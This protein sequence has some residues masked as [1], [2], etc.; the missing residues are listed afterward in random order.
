M[1]L[2]AVL[3]GILFLSSCSYYRFRSVNLVKVNS[4]KAYIHSE[5]LHDHDVFIRVNKGAASH[6]SVITVS[7]VT[8]SDDSIHFSLD[9]VP[10]F[11]A[12]ENYY[13]KG[14]DKLNNSRKKM[15][16]NE[17]KYSDELDFVNQ[18][19]FL[20]NDSLASELENTV[21]IQRNQITKM[22]VIEDN[23]LYGFL[24]LLGI[25]TGLIVILLPIF[26]LIA[27]SN[28]QFKW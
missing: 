18:I 9:S 4:E 22:Y 7:D 12:H 15:K 23:G 28:I 25:L 2:F 5:E 16:V 17:K 26:V 8:F 6:D 10:I 3:I 20:F 14:L 13:N 24:I 19:H 1:R 27:L 21:S 11:A